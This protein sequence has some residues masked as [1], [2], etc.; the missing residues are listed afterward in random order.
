MAREA[1]PIS[2]AVFDLPAVVPLS[3]NYIV[4]EGFASTVDTLAGN[5]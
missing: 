4:T 1:R 2:A 3:K 5:H